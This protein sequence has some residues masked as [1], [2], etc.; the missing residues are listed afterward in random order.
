MPGASSTDRPVRRRE[1]ARVIVLAGDEVLLQG[2]TDP[3]IPGSRF[4]QTP[5]GGVE[6]GEPLLAAAS[7][8]LA[9]ETGLVVDPAELVGPVAVR[10]L[11]RGYS[12]RILVQRESFF[13]L[14]TGRFDPETSGLTVDERSRHV[15]TGWFPLRRLPPLTWPANLAELA[16]VGRGEPL[17][18]GDIEESTVPVGELP[19]VAPPEA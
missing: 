11:I 14:E 7:R 1:A 16:A 13:I 6:D 5:G 15:E 12:D 19:P 18:L 4:W 10:R 9:E 8:E 2:D 3:G 17:D